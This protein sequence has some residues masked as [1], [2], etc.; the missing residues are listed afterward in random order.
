MVITKRPRTISWVR[1][2]WFWIIF[3]PRKSAK[4][5]S[6]W[7]GRKVTTGPK[8]WAKN[9]RM[10]V[11][12]WLSMSECLFIWF[13]WITTKVFCGW[14]FIFST[15]NVRE[16]TSTNAWCLDEC[17]KDETTQRVLKKMEFVTN[18]PDT[19]TEYLQLLRYEIGQFYTVHH[20]YIE[21]IKN[22]P[23]GSRILTLYMYLSDVEEG[24]TMPIWPSWLCHRR[25]SVHAYIDLNSYVTLWIFLRRWH[26]LSSS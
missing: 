11:F 26:Q 3:W 25:G 21:E 12:Q 14:R 15:P 8:M 13:C 6:S 24:K 2:W 20:D 4:G 18:V 17:F 23:D 16:R 7:V 9:K 5:S 1:G 22:R 19:N 10:A